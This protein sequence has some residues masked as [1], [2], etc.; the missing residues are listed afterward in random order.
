[1]KLTSL[2]M[3]EL[4]I[5]FKMQFQHSSAARYSTE[6]VLVTAKTIEGAQGLGEGCPRSYV[7]S[8]TLA[9]VQEF[10]AAHHNKFLKIGSL[11]A[12]RVW[13]DSNVA[14]IDKNPAAFCAVE[15]ALLD[16]L[17]KEA[18]QSVEALL[19]LPELTGEFQYTGVLGI[20]NPEHFRAQLQQYLD[21]GFRDFKVKVFGESA[22]DQTN[23]ETL[24]AC[25]HDDIRVRLDA[26]NL[27]SSP[28]EVIEYIRD[29]NFPIFAVEE[30]LGSFD[31][32][33]CRAVFEQLETAVILDESFTREEM[34][35]HIQG[36][37]AP[38]IV[39][40]RISKMGG[41]IRSLAVAA[42]ARNLNIPIII[43]AQVG[44]TSILTRAALTIAN[45][46]RD[47]LIAQEGAY[48]THLLENDVIDPPIMFG[49]RGILNASLASPALS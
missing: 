22:I 2:T 42:R 6:A 40:L 15:L 27:W 38:W 5:P 31:Y 48:G 30:P 39:N 35:Q 45:A 7:T 37:P 25:G 32:D 21:L 29:L 23:T 14:E 11:E 33:G 46:Y 44:E 13:I 36:S 4:N 16:V 20:K 28:S 34:F 17:A 3:E 49:Q 43:G 8:E 9:T 19:A 41:L 26:N 24:K 18:G 47:N 12:L 10:F 1:M